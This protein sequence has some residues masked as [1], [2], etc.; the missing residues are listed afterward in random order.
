MA[1]VY[2]E[3]VL[4]L[5]NVSILLTVIHMKIYIHQTLHRVIENMHKLYHIQYN[6]VHFML[7][8]KLLCLQSNQKYRTPSSLSLKFC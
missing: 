6:M 4:H 7:R 2:L 1:S 3:F 8:I 5:V